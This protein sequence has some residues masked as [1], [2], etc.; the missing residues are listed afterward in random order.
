[1]IPKHLAIGVSAVLAQ[2]ELKHGPGETWKKLPI[3]Y[4][5]G[6]IGRHLLA[7]YDGEIYDKESGQS[8]MAH[9]AA[10]CAFILELENREG[11]K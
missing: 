5:L 9:V 7:Y 1:M 4:H 10:R 11:V 2:G 3:E 8:H 6:A